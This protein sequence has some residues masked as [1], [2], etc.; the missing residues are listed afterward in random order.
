M[1]PFI[2]HEAE[3]PKIGEHFYPREIET[4]ILFIRK[5]W[6]RQQRASR[7]GIKISFVVDKNI[8]RK[9]LGESI[10]E[11]IEEILGYYYC[12][13][14]PKHRDFGS[15]INSRGIQCHYDIYRLKDRFSTNK[16]LIDEWDKSATVLRKWGGNEKVK[17]IREYSKMLLRETRN[18]GLLVEETFPHTHI[19]NFLAG[20]DLSTSLIDRAQ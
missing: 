10:E 4:D 8:Y 12:T 19:A 17:C 13:G 6:K 18:R 11:Q 5:M 15:S 16:A 9:W 20:E 1:F 2:C 3:S 14:C 7:D